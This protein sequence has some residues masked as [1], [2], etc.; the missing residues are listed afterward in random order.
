VDF[1]LGGGAER[2]LAEGYFEKEGVLREGR[3]TGKE[4]TDEVFRA[5]PLVSGKE[6]G[7]LTRRLLGKIVEALEKDVPKLKDILRTF[8]NS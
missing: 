1:C 4:G 5:A 8:E 3:I 7:E 6:R 2:F